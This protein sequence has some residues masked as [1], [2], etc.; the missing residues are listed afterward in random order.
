MAITTEQI[1]Q[2]ADKLAE[3]GIKPTQT[4][5]REA[6]GGGSFTTIAEALRTWRKEQETVTQLQAVVIPQ[7]ITDRTQT[8]TAQI[9]EIAQQLAN[10]RLAKER[11]ALAH[12]EALLIGE[13]DEMQKV[14]ATL[15]SEQSELLA[16]LDQINAQIATFKEALEL[17]QIELTSADQRADA[18][19]QRLDQSQADN[20]QLTQKVNE[21]AE[22]IA[23]HI[24]T[25]TDLKT[26]KATLETTNKNFIERL[27]QSRA[28]IKA[29]QVRAETNMKDLADLSGKFCNVQGQNKTLS[30]QLTKAEALTKEQ[31]EKIEKLTADLAT[32][33][34]TV[35]ATKPKTATEAKQEKANNEQPN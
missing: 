12:K 16:Q 20:A 22:I 18:L 7:D 15:E 13:N 24:N 21:Q 11:E 14:V 34:A 33:K 5:V 3:Q 1:H 28:D 9:W 2:T 31:A 32:A 26:E 6:L 19:K 25:I 10:E 27:E 17:N 4:N 8:L 30:E 35:G 23:K 29:E